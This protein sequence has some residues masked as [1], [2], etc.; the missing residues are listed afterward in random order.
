[1]LL[2]KW[3]DITINYLKTWTLENVYDWSIQIFRGKL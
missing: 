3:R 1:M 2:K